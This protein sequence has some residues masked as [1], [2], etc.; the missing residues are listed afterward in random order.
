[1]A[2]A[3]EAAA[4]L[5]QDDIDAMLAS[6]DAPAAE[7]AAKDDDVLDLTKPVATPKATESS[8]LEFRASEA[9]AEPAPEP[10]AVDDAGWGEI[11]P[12]PMP[13]SRAPSAPTT[14]V[15]RAVGEALLAP[16]A[17][18]A[19]ASAFS[20]LAHTILGQNARTLDDLVE[21]MLR[22]MLKDWLDDNLPT[23]VERLVR[24][25]IERVSR[26]PKR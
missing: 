1:V 14:A 23:I 7:P 24:A 2:P 8:E 9:K 3:E 16:E 19:V 15:S 6:F 5:G 21:E 10:E 11:E 22:P 17:G 4:D 20:S 26:G 12:E 25:E 18:T 13:M